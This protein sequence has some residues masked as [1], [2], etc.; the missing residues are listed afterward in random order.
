MEIG[1]LVLLSLCVL[2]A[3]AVLV[4]TYFNRKKST[5]LEDMIRMLE[6]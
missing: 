3:G 6:K 4:G 2:I 5:T 1:F